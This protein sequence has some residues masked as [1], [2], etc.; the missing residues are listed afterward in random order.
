MIDT[1]KRAAKI[2]RFHDKDSRKDLIFDLTGAIKRVNK[3]TIDATPLSKPA[4][5]RV[6]NEINV[7]NR[8]EDCIKR[9]NYVATTELRFIM[10]V[11]R[12]MGGRPVRGAP[13][14]QERSP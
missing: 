14:T 5:N 6:F 3:Q 2:I 8:I 11:F 1:S 12:A 10:R 13:I 7:A 9:N 4:Y